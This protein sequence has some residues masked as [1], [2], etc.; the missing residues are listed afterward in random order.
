MNANEN[1]KEMGVILSRLKQGDL[2]P[3]M[4]SDDNVGMILYTPH[5][6]SDH[7]VHMLSNLHSGRREYPVCIVGLNGL[8]GS[9]RQTL[10]REIDRMVG[11]HYRVHQF[12]FMD[13]VLNAAAELFD[14][15]PTNFRCNKLSEAEFFD[16]T[17]EG[18]NMEGVGVAT[19][20]L[21][22][23]WMVREVVH[24][25]LGKQHLVRLMQNK[26]NRI[27]QSGRTSVTLIIINDVTTLEEALL[28]HDMGGCIFRIERPELEQK[29]ENKQ[30][31][32]SL[33]QGTLK[34]TGTKKELYFQFKA[35]MS[36]LIPHIY[37]R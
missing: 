20:Q 22:T 17:G 27:M 26:V 37:F 13:P 21:I 11:S 33:I 7:P 34:N 3:P 12:R 16:S 9:G 29:E 31:S 36:R 32:G 19:P 8:P 28:I 23:N 6:A 25:F 15:P 18:Y 30:L 5:T 35:E 10:S 2:C 14:I 1:P 4:D 24:P